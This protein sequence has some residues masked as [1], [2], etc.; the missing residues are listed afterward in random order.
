M[1]IYTNTHLLGH[2]SLI[3]ET[4]GR[5]K[6]RGPRQAWPDFLLSGSP[7]YTEPGYGSRFPSLP[8]K[9]PS[10]CSFF[11]LTWLSQRALWDSLETQTFTRAEHW[12]LLQLIS[13]WEQDFAQIQIMGLHACLWPPHFLLGEGAVIRHSG[14]GRGTIP[15]SGSW[16]LTPSHALLIRL[17]FRDA[18]ELRYTT[19]WSFATLT[20]GREIKGERKA[21][22]EGRSSVHEGVVFGNNF[23]DL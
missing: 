9:Q 16:L 6:A 15:Q 4:P 8:G 17:T 2:G 19:V 18:E 1:F 22:C 13:G 12:T 7:R 21:P 3:Y 10:S 14:P 5:A 20:D 11:F 23:K